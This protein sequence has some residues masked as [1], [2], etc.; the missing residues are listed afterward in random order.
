M[1]TSK[2]NVRLSSP[3]A[4]PQGERGA[5]I[6]KAHQ[7][8]ASMIEKRG[9]TVLLV[10]IRETPERAEVEVYGYQPWNLASVH[11]DGVFA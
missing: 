9:G 2:W 11:I 7:L 10:T 1:P 8:F 5:E 6:D 3:V 4:A